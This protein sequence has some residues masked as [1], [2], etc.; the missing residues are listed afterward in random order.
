LPILR[1]CEA[2]N[3][4]LLLRTQELPYYQLITKLLRFHVRCHL[5]SFRE[6]ETL[7]ENERAHARRTV[8]SFTC[9]YQEYLVKRVPTRR[10]ETTNWEEVPHKQTPPVPHPMEIDAGS[11]TGPTLFTT[12]VICLIPALVIPIHGVPPCRPSTPHCKKYTYMLRC[13][14]CFPLHAV[15]AVP[16][17]QIPVG[18]Q[19]KGSSG[20]SA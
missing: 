1:I 6:R 9:H 15:C 19:R 4:T 7:L 2:H 16:S 11:R 10:V 5:A 20:G 13:V 14:P 12:G 17:P 18:T 8:A 3:S